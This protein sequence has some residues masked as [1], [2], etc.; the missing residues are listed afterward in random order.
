MVKFFVSPAAWGATTVPAI[1]G[2]AVFAV[3]VSSET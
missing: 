3:P 1:G 2:D